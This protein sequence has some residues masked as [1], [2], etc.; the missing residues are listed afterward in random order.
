MLQMFCR[1]DPLESGVFHDQLVNKSL[2]DS[3]VHVLVN[4]RSDR[5]ATLPLIVRRQVG[6]AATERDAERAA[7]DD[8]RFDRP[9]SLASRLPPH[10]TGE[11]ILSTRPT[12]W[13][14]L[15][16]A[17]RLG[18]AAWNRRSGDFSNALL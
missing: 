2:V 15:R 5:D 4:C 1:W 14:G 9:P 8:H 10:G 17:L 6:P 18:G 13:P 12:P 7:G 16:T 3:D 11:F